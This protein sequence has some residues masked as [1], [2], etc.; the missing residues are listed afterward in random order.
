MIAATPQA[1]QRLED[2]IKAQAYGLGFD[3]VGI[4][5][6]GPAPTAGCTRRV[7]RARIR[8]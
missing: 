8:R 6:L 5:T 7:A 4:T 1:N 3:L 2:L